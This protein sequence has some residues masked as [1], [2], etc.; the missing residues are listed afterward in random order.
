[1]DDFLQNLR[2][3]KNKK[4]G[5]KMTRKTS[6]KN[7]Q[8]AT[9]MSHFNNGIQQRKKSFIANNNDVM[10]PTSDVGPSQLEQAINSLNSQMDFFSQHQKHMA[11]AQERTADMIERQVVAI[12]KVL[13]QFNSAPKQYRD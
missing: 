8:N 12:E 6:K 2:N 7:N 13:Y 9:Q 10:K 4:Q 1:M 11:K 3:D 5:A